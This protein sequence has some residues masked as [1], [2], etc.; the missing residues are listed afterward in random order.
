[1]LPS[2]AQTSCLSQRR[3]ILSVTAAH[4]NQQLHMSQEDY[5]NRTSSDFLWT[6]EP[7]C[8]LNYLFK[9]ICLN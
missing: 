5:I 1:M 9:A 6:L 2:I 7:S 8:L 3:A 4:H